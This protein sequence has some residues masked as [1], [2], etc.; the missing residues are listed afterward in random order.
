[1]ADSGMAGNAD[2]GLADDEG[3]RIDDLR[4]AGACEVPEVPGRRTGGVHAAVVDGRGAVFADALELAAA[5][6]GIEHGEVDHLSISPQLSGYDDARTVALVDQLRERLAEVPGVLGVGSSQIPV[7]TGTDMGTNIT[8]E[9]RQNLDSDDRH[10]NFDAISPHYFS[11]MRVPQLS[12]REFNA[13]DSAKS[14]KVAIINEAMAKEF[15][16][17]RNPIGVH[18]GM[19]REMT[20]SSIS[21]S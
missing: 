12:G 2:R 7:L 14:P 19:A 4:G 8:V 9:G 18:F 13:V 3:S 5:K 17:N 21:R 15:F 1:L 16:P 6:P 11:T 20:S 10:V